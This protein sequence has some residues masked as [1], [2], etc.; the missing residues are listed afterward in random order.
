VRE[1]AR[2]KR[3]EHELDQRRDQVVTEHREEAGV[4]N[5]QAEE[6]E[7]RA[8]IAEQEAQRARAEAQLR[9]EKAAMHERGMADH[10]L[11]GDHERD[12][13]EGT[14]AVEGEG[15]SGGGVGDGGDGERTSAYEEGQRAAHD[16]SR[17]ED[18]QQ[19]RRQEE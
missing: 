16:P 9:E 3:R 6:A 8:R 7:Q 4:R 10:D 1:R 5:R 14:S 18:F 12:R 2:V 11:I 19:G 15:A 17:V 13:F